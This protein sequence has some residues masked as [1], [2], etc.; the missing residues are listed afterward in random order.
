VKP[1]IARKS[2]IPDDIALRVDGAKRFA[3]GKSMVVKDA[4]LAKETPTMTSIRV[5]ATR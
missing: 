2:I 5:N 3:P 4:A 1:G